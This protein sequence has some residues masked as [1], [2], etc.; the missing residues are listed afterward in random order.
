MQV[1]MLTVGLGN[2]IMASL[3]QKCVLTSVLTHGFSLN[4]AY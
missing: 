1:R 4:F 2:I 3:T